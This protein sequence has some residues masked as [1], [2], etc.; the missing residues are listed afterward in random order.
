MPIIKSKEIV[1][2]LHRNCTERALDAVRL[3]TTILIRV[4]FRKNS[5]CG[6]NEEEEAI[7]GLHLE[8]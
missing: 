6:K 8:E 2:I 4:R 7:E 3:S 1:G 5:D